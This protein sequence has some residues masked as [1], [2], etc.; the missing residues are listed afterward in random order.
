MN[1]PN[2]CELSV[3]VP[4]YSRKDGGR[5]TKAI[6]CLPAQLT[7]ADEIA[8]TEDFDP[9]VR[10]YVVDLPPCYANHPVVQRNA[11]R[12]PLPLAFFLD[13]VQRQNKDSLIWVLDR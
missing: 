10:D 6:P 1:D 12:N 8:T 4:V 3:R 5:S 7:L 13:E 11:P 2:M 9:R